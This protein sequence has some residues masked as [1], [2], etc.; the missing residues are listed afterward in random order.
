MDRLRCVRVAALAFAVVAWGCGGD[1]GGLAPSPLP[2]GDAADEDASRHDAVLGVDAFKPEASAERDAAV[3]TGH[4]PEEPSPDAPD[5]PDEAD[6]FEE[7]RDGAADAGL[8]GG[9]QGSVDAGDA[10]SEAADA[11][12]DLWN[13]AADGGDLVLSFIMITPPSPF[14]F[15]RMSVSLAA[16]GVYYDPSTGGSPVRD[17]TRLV[18]WSSSRP[19]DLLVSNTP[20]FQGRLT[21]INTSSSI[22]V[23]A[24]LGNVSGTT[25]IAVGSPSLV[26][27]GIAPTRWAI[28]KGVPFRLYAMGVWSTGDKLDFTDNV[29]WSTSDSNIFSIDGNLVT[30]KAVGTASITAKVA[31]LTDTLS[32]SV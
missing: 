31:N 26:E 15:P 23:T 16:T 24:T 12:G 29:A 7:G 22:T 9:P 27:I 13:G 17:I 10:G 30:P 4:A 32:V 28:P 20:G 19:A 21:A 18:T 14:L 1:D 2:D 5:A 6:A 11:S 25:D 8:E 3:E